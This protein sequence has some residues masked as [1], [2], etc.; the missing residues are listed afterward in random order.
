MRTVAIITIFILNPIIIFAQFDTY[1]KSKIYSYPVEFKTLSPLESIPIS[2]YNKIFVN[3]QFG[4]QYYYN[5]KGN[6]DDDDVARH[7]S[8][9]SEY[10]IL[11]KNF[12]EITSVYNNKIYLLG[13]LGLSTEY[14]TLIFRV[15]QYR[16]EY[17]LLNNYTKTGQLLSAIC[18]FFTE[19]NEQNIIYSSFTEKNE[20]IQKTVSENVDMEIIQKTFI[21]DKDGHFRVTHLE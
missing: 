2:T 1:I 11:D 21:L 7:I 3:Y 5:I 19:K 10:T 20:I 18:L 6:Y 13:K 14:E 17:I 12:N 9:K 16:D 8:E 4:E 15:E